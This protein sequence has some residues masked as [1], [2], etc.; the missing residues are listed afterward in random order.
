MALAT[1]YRF[2]LPRGYIDYDGNVHREGIMRVATVRDEIEPLE[3]PRVI[4][5]EAYLIVMLLSNVIVELGD[6]RDVTP[7]VVENMFATDLVYLKSLYEQINAVDDIM[8]EVVCPNCG[9]QH[10]Q[11]IG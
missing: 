9:H 8:I 5:N 4:A 3:H 7:D 10:T 1:E 2:V 6:L 11:M